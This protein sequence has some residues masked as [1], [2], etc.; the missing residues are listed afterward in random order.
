MV[1]DTGGQSER[2]HPEKVVPWQAEHSC[3]A[4]RS[5]LRRPQE[6]AARSQAAPVVRALAIILGCLFILVALFAEQHPNRH[7]ERFD[8]PPTS[9]KPTD[10]SGVSIFTIIDKDS[11]PGL[12]VKKGSR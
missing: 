10:I 2:H 7:P 3:E 6:R 5:P 1:N 11:G 8:Q 4:E 9:G 12:Y